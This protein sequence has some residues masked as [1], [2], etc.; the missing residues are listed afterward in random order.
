MDVSFFLYKQPMIAFARGERLRPYSVPTYFVILIKPEIDVLTK[1]AFALLDTH[2]GRKRFVYPKFATDEKIL[3]TQLY[4]DFAP[5]IFLKHPKIKQVR[6]SLL[7]AGAQCVQL[8]GTGSAVYA[9][10]T[11]KNKAL[12]V[13]HNIHST[14]PQAIFTRTIEFGS[15]S[16]YKL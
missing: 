16:R 15:Q 12:R 11:D 1:E 5:I 7:E 8:T 14:Y 4:N 6:D 2:E 13:F 3:A 9:L 10:F